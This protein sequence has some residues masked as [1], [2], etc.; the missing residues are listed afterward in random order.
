LQPVR[1]PRPSVAAALP[2]VLA[3]RD[4]LRAPDFTPARG[5]GDRLAVMIAGISGRV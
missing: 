5:F 1:L 4:L 3:Q 2:A